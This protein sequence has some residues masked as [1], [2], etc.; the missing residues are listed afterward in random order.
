MQ[1]TED[2]WADSLAKPTLVSLGDRLLKKA[3]PISRN[4]RS[5][6]IAIRTRR[7]NGMGP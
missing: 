5:P 3:S 4:P 7:S 2:G 1:G 6:R